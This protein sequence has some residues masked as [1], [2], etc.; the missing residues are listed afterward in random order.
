M[1]INLLMETDEI[2]SIGSS[3]SVIPPSSRNGDGSGQVESVTMSRATKLPPNFLSRSTTPPLQ[4]VAD[5]RLRASIALRFY[6]NTASITAANKGSQ[7][8]ISGR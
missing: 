2:A 3:S 1:V 4:I 7:S 6:A 5:Y 8:L